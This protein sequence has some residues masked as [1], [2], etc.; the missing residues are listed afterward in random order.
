LGT[1]ESNIQSSGIP[2]ILGVTV[3]HPSSNRK[4]LRLPFSWQHNFQRNGIAWRS[5]KNAAELA[6]AEKLSATSQ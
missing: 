2:P 3:H 1:K 4:F 5:T 6:P